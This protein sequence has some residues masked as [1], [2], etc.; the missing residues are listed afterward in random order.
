MDKIFIRGITVSAR[1]GVTE[2]ELK[3]KQKLVIDLDIQK[4]LSKAYDTDDLEHTIDYNEVTLGIKNVVEAKE[5]K[6]LETL[7]N[8]I[9]KFVLRQYQPDTVSVKVHKP[10]IASLKLNIKDVGVRITRT[11]E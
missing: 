11:K 5:Y 3:V 2:K 1:C 10:E 6:L 4:D 9:A 8:E 7:A